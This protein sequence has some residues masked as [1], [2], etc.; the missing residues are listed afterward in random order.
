MGRYG[1]IVYKCSCGL[2]FRKHPRCPS[3]HALCGSEHLSHL[4]YFHGFRMCEQCARRW[5][6]L[7]KQFEFPL[8]FHQIVK[9]VKYVSVN[10]KLGPVE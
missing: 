4:V 6:L 8:S 7:E 2:S 3:C 10:Q 9:G 5:K 1:R